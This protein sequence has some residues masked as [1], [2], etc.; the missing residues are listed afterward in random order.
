[1]RGYDPVATIADKY[2]I[3]RIRA[4]RNKTIGDLQAAQRALRNSSSSE[5]RG[6]RSPR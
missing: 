2:Q 3:D 4:E 1:M 5:W 6:P